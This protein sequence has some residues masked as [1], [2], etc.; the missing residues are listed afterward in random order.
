MDRGLVNWKGTFLT[1]PKR[2]R[3]QVALDA[4]EEKA[5]I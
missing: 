2:L 5:V 1:V 4:E 3:P